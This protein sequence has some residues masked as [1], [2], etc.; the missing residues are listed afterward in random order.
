MDRGDTIIEQRIA[1]RVLVFAVDDA[2]FGLHLDW[3]EAVVPRSGLVLHSIK[4]SGGEVQPFLV[5]NGEPAFPVELRALLGLP[6]ADVAERSA[7]LFV[8]SG[9]YLLA[10]QVD[11]CV[12]VQ[13]I[14]L[15]T[16][17]P[18]PTSLI[19]DGGI[20]VGHLV[21]LDGSVVVVLDPSRL[22][23][24]ALRDRLAPALREALQYQERARDIAALWHEIASNPSSGALRKYARLCRR[25]GRH[26]EARAA[27]AVLRYLTPG[28][29]VPSNGSDDALLGELI[30]LAEQ[31]CSARIVVLAPDGVEVGTVHLDS[32]RVVGAS[33]ER[34]RGL[35]AL[36]VLLA[37]RDVQCRLSSGPN[38]DRGD[39]LTGNTV[40]LAIEAL[41]A[42]NGERRPRPVR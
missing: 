38:A 36:G 13:E 1:S 7:A 5:H 2:Y 3:I 9:P 22:V 29:A 18:I 25:N 15:A 10:L 14:D 11:G 20:P 37:M 30:Q 24:G 23:D 33:H 8:R 4:T 17:P 19:G 31:Q 21:D 35:P 39:H 6:A 34:E 16:Q 40:A 41:A 12:G 27:R 26:K 32:G 28:A 42:R